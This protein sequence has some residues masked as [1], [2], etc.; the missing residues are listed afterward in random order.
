[1]RTREYG[2]ISGPFLS[3]LHNFDISTII[4]QA[5]KFPR[6][7]V[8]TSLRTSLLQSCHRNL[9]TYLAFSFLFFKFFQK[10]SSFF[11]PLLNPFQ[12]N[13]QITFHRFSPFTLFFPIFS[14][15]FHSR[16]ITIVS[17]FFSQ[18]YS[19]PLSTS[20]S[21]LFSNQ[22]LFPLIIQEKKEKVLSIKKKKKEKN[23]SCRLLS[24]ITRL[25]APADFRGIIFR[26]RRR[27]AYS[28]SFGLRTRSIFFNARGRTR[29]S[30]WSRTKRV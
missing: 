30:A 19:T 5:S 12:T 3:V 10:Y 14:K 8:Q 9:T 2:K 27:G 24:S 11:E 26:D 4:Q 29:A 23:K 16:Q 25:E 22:S 28:A 1:M 21:N 15:S 20:S 7:A 17:L 6:R 18:K 13:T